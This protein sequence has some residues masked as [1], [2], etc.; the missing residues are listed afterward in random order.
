MNLFSHLIIPILDR[1]GLIMIKLSMSKIYEKD[2]KDLCV[3]AHHKNNKP[4]F[5]NECDDT[6]ENQQW[7][8]SEEALFIIGSPHQSA[9]CAYFKKNA[10][11]KIFNYCDNFYFGHEEENDEGEDDDSVNLCYGVEYNLLIQECCSDGTIQVIG[12]CY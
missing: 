9:R 4:L 1:N 8:Y 5:L 3:E 10:S 7:V 6:N 12:N 2:N 11:L